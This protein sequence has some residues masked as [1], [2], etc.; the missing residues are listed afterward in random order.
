MSSLQCPPG[1]ACLPCSLVMTASVGEETAE[2]VIGHARL[3][4]VLGNTTAALIETGQEKAEGHYEEEK[5]KDQGIELGSLQ[6]KYS[7]C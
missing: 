3:M 5:E 7:I 6:G 1:D 2:K 4:P